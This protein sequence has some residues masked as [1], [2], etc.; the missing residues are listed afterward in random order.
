MT[1][2][3]RTKRKIPKSQSELMA[4]IESLREALD[5]NRQALNAHVS[6]RD[7]GDQRIKAW[8]RQI[9]ELRRKQEDMRQK[10]AEAERKIPRIQAHIETIEE[11]LSLLTNSPLIKRLTR[12]ANQVLD[13]QRK[14]D[15]LQND[16]EEKGK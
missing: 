7:H 4:E 12:A 13:L 15:E 5:Y 14:L 10:Q 16:D 1:K 11:R 8:E 2:K 9:A 6:N 3:A